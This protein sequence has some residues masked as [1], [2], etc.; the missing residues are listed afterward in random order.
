MA[1][2]VSIAPEIIYDI[3]SNLDAK[4]NQNLRLVCRKICSA[5]ESLA[6]SRIVID[7]NRGNVEYNIRKLQGY[8]TRSTIATNYVHTLIIRS[9]AVGSASRL[10]RAQRFVQ[11][12]AGGSIVEIGPPG[13]SM[14]TFEE[15]S[16]LHKYLHAA[17]LQLNRVESVEWFTHFQ[18]PA[19]AFPTVTEYLSNQRVP[20]FSLN[21]EG[22]C[23]SAFDLE[24]VPPLRSF[25]VTGVSTVSHIPKVVQRL[26][27]IIA[28]S[29]H[30]GRLHIDAT[31]YNSTSE[32]PTLHDFFVG[33]DIS[34][35]LPLKHLTVCNM[36]VK[37]DGT[38]L[39]HLQSL[40]SLTIH[41]DLASPDSPPSEIW[42]TLEKEAIHLRY[43]NV[44]CSENALDNQYKDVSVPL[45]AQQ[46]KTATSRYWNERRRRKR[47]EK[48]NAAHK[49]E[50][51]A[52]RADNARL[53]GDLDMS[54]KEGLV[55]EEDAKAVIDCFQERITLLTK[56]RRVHMRERVQLKR[57]C[58][59]IMRL[60]ARLKTRIQ[61]Q[62]SHKRVFKLTTRGVYT[63][64]ARAMACYLASVGT[65]EKKIGETIK[66]IGDM[67]GVEVDR[68]MSSRTV[69]RAV[70]ESGVAA[71]VQLGYEMAKSDKLTYSSDSTSH[72]HIEYESRTIAV[73]VV[74]YTKPNALPEWKSRSLGIGT[75]TNHTSQ[76]QVDGLRKR[77]E[78]ISQVFNGSPL[79]KREGLTFKIDDF[80]YKLIG[81]SGDHAA[82]QKKSHTIMKEWKL[83]VILQRLGEEA[84]FA[85]SVTRV[86]ALLAPL[87]ASQIE[88]MGGYDVW[89]STSE[90]VRARADVDIVRE[91]GRQVLAGMSD[92]DR[93]RLTLFIRT[94]CCMHKDLNTVKGGDKAMQ[95]F[96]KETKKTPPILLANKDNAAVLSVSNHALEPTAAERRAAEVS[97]RGASHATMLGGLICRNKDKKKGQQD[98][99]DWYMEEKVGNRVPYPDVSNTRYGSHG[100]ASATLIVYRDHFIRFMEFVR[101]AKD[102]PGLTNIEQNFMNAIQDI[103]TLTELCVLAMYNINVSRPFMQHVRLHDNLMDLGPFFQKKVGFLKAVTADPTRWLHPD[104]SH[105]DGTLDGRE[106]DPWG[107][108]VM[109]T[110]HSVMR[111]CPDLEEAVVA[112]LKGAEKIF[113]E[114]FSDEFIKGGDIDR[115]ATEDR[116]ELYFSS[117]NDLNEGG[118][119]SWRL[120]QRHRP[121]ETISKFNAGF[122]SRRNT[123]AIFH[124]TVLSSEED[125]AYLRKV[126]RERDTQ[127][128]QKQIK[129]AQLAA[130]AQKVVENRD[131]NAKRQQKKTTRAATITE[132]GKVLVLEDAQI[133]KL[134]NEDLNRQLDWHRDNEKG[135]PALTE[136]V[137]LKSHMSVKADRVRELKSAVKRYETLQEAVPLPEHAV[138]VLNDDGVVGSNQDDL[139]VSDY[140]DNM[141]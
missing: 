89:N 136:L 121:S 106:R 52:L 34:S 64:Q 72:K 78:E 51:K 115:L 37:L 140:E 41:H 102:K 103:P 49:A 108:L 27:N 119:G 87:K 79:A 43:I 36:V 8:A 15:Q 42:N 92:K 135:F 16:T 94:G 130:D 88:M 13:T 7:V 90:D 6:L 48:S 38:T 82:D 71:E 134:N 55:K 101:D 98:T 123:T 69:E 75:S 84:L 81:T 30:L 138:N 128:L 91:V 85:M 35:P 112:F 120:G 9:L 104:A 117:T 3:G 25:K 109:E 73:R 74:D 66:T 19:W 133:D 5:I 58:E 83:D 12:N 99:Y 63:K 93:E 2:I 23:S 44:T 39:P 14:G 22:S 137:P 56:E 107:N 131:K 31:C 60:K 59:Q 76:T 139:Y 1:S 57:K 127:K 53:Q 70:L 68:V 50:L 129:E 62:D 118:P 11:T 40:Q 132:T 141:V 54:R 110:V 80:A 17:L 124:Q 65:A 33:L 4:S 97:K 114:R 113:S 111:D 45:L 24:L 18:D 67:I 46:A 26:A 125:E 116:K 29:P 21:L 28:K 126:A 122:I 32:S 47:L 20:N 95:A 61:K 86:V 105:T 96:W 77:L 10:E 100:E